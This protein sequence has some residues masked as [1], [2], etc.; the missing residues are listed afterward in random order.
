VA[1]ADAGNQ[2]QDASDSVTDS[3]A[4]VD[5]APAHPVPPASDVEP[6]QLSKLAAEPPNNRWGRLA[7]AFTLAAFIA[8]GLVLWA[9][10][11]FR[12][13][14][15]DQF[16]IDNKLVMHR[17]MVLMASLGGG[18]VLGVVA[19]IV[20][21][22]LLRRRAQPTATLERWT[23]FL[24]PL[25]LLPAFPIVFRHRPWADRH[26]ALLLVVLVTTL[27]VEVLVARSMMA[28]PDGVCRLW[29]A[30]AKRVPAFLR[31]HGPLVVVWSGVL[32]YAAFMSFYTVRWH[33]KLQTH[34]FDLSINN[35][36]MFRGLKGHFLSSPV[37]FPDDPGRYLATHA[38]IGQYLF[39]P[40]YALFPRPETLLVI[41]AAFVGLAALPLYAFARRHVS[42]WLA[43]GVSLAYLAYF[44]MH[45]ANFYEVKWLLPATFFV[46]ATVWAA[47]AER[48]VLCGLA[49]V[50]A[51]IMR[52]D[53]PIGL[54]VVGTFLLL[55]G[56]RPRAGLVMAVVSTAWF[57]VIRFVIM[58]RA[59]T[60]W[61]PSMYKGLWAEGGHGFTSVIE[62]IVTNPVFVLSKIVV[63]DKLIYLLHL[64][65]PLAFLPARRW[66]LWAAFI[67]GTIL[68]LL[69]TDYGPTVTYSFEYVMYWTPYLFLATP[70]A[71]A[72]IRDSGDRG[73][74]R[75]HAATVS[76]LLASAVLS[77]N[78]GAFA[79]RDDFK[80]GFFHVNFSYT[81]A[82]RKRY[83]DL[84]KVIRLIPKDASVAATENVGPHV[85][86]RESMY[87]MRYGPHHADYILA[88]RNELR[89][90]DARKDLIKVLRDKKYGVLKRLD[91][92]A[93]LKRGY[94]TSG[95]AQLLRDW[96]L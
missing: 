81:P 63:Q 80:G 42:E 87:A 60:W 1:G 4:S 84:L 6:P 46:F 30:I 44:P 77:F 38:K 47:D 51:L 58:D 13:R 95:N 72:A 12:A 3:T 26:E 17:R 15:V 21:L 43:A 68:T 34:N 96:G 55:S 22:I 88:G 64:F 37:V 92:F 32:F 40:I 29:T 16:L 31:R 83:D 57:V 48:W 20:A 23:W 69:T 82:E 54:A 70:L 5:A 45:S 85:S 49:F 65:V 75:M 76:M 24:A 62:T 25:G 9:Q 36:L 11:T 2:P 19:A 67:P 18:C 52:E 14:W 59:G 86:S 8:S 41:Q 89:L 93:L 53:M 33:H 61:F 50:P 27:V 66:Y 90:G 71:L 39:L 35:N 74:P 78:Y 79:R 73:R 56:Y 7:R 28:V 10:F 94:E 91:D